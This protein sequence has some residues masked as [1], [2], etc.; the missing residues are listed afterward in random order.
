MRFHWFLGKNAP[1]FFYN[2]VN[3]QENQANY[4][5]GIVQLNDTTE[6]RQTI[7][8]LQTQ[9]DQGFPS[10]PNFSQTTGTGSPD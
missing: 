5:Q 7:Q 4:A 1:S 10:S 2:V 3:R 8:S 9:L 6:L